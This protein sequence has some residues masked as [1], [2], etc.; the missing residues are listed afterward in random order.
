MVKHHKYRENSLR[1]H[2]EIHTLRSQVAP[3]KP[4][5]I[6]CKGSSFVLSS[7]FQKTPL[8][9]PLMCSW[10]I[11]VMEAE[12]TSEL[13]RIA[14]N[15]VGLMSANSVNAGSPQVTRLR[16]QVEHKSRQDL[17]HDGVDVCVRQRRLETAQ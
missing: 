9:L 1:G 2:G 7:S 8:S 6:P 3:Q 16:S 17:V 13:W 15:L 5:S 12:I 14:V 10:M 4:F 11:E